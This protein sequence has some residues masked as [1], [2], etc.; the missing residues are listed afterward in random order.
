MGPFGYTLVSSVF[1]LCCSLF[2]KSKM[3]KLFFWM[4]L[5]TLIG[6][7]VLYLSSDFYTG[8]GIT[9]ATIFHLLYGWRGLP[10]VQAFWLS[11]VVIV[12]S[13]IITFLVVIMLRCRLEE[14]FPFPV[15][16][17]LLAAS[18][19]FFSMATHPSVA[20]L[21]NIYSALKTEKHSR[22]LDKE[23]VNDDYR[24]SG[25]TKS[26]VY[27]YLE[28]YERTF[29]ENDVFPNLTSSLAI[30]KDDALD[31][32][33]IHQ[34]PL[35]QWTMAGIAASQCGIPLASTK[36]NR[37]DSSVS[38]FLMPGSVCVSDILSQH[39][40]SIKYIGGA[41]LAFS[42]KDVFFESH[43]FDKAYGLQYFKQ[44]FPDVPTSSWGVYDDF[45][46]AMAKEEVKAELESGAPFALFMLTLD[47]HSPNG[48]IT[49]SCEKDESYASQNNPMLDAI[50]CLDRL[51]SKF[52]DDLEAILDDYN[53]DDVVIVVSS[54]HLQMQSTA[55]SAL[56]PHQ[57]KRRNLFFIIDPEQAGR[58]IS[59]DG[60]TMDIAPTLLSVL[61]WNV[62][63][64]ALGRNLLSEEQTLLE[65]YG[66]DVFYSMVM[67]WQRYLWR[68]SI[69]GKG[70]SGLEQEDELMG[71]R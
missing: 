5:S 55:L 56:T 29:F 37:S 18:A 60:T 65:K 54:D 35:T 9:E 69:Q 50:K 48:H 45:L 22:Y 63:S 6:L 20:Q 57:D 12:Y 16:L 41:D 64:L 67:G 39:G 53:R 27:L 49:P 15:A 38:R 19:A 3:Q 7:S 14:Y 4:L 33:N 36:L 46:F 71:N 21:M 51:A 13:F 42:S 1:L 43:S 47:T 30:I 24:N 8:E 11:L 2:L 34:S 44:R 68:N 59:R 58:V 66:S 32:L 23:V 70:V 17:F 31:F 62:T 52:I 61:G 10:L 25:K 28:S 26:L 40:Y